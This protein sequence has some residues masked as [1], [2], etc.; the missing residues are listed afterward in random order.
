MTRVCRIHAVRRLLISAACL[1]MPCVAQA[2]DFSFLA[3]NAG[4]EAAVE[5]A[6]AAL[7]EHVVVAYKEENRAT[8]LDN[9]FRLQIV[10]GRYM[11]ALQTLTK[12]H[13]LTAD[14]RS[15]QTAADNVQDQIFTQAKLIEAAEGVA[16]NQAFQRAFREKFG[17]LDNR[18]SALV[19]RTL[20]ASKQ[21]LRSSFETAVAKQ[22]G[23]STINLPDALALVRAYQTDKELRTYAPLVQPL[24]AEDDQRRYIIEK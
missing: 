13:D 11:D 15:T 22:K 20:T 14:P 18:T 12:L 6:M 4:D 2:Q 5:N 3:G 19:V 7:A 17:T 8:F 10:S 23:R 16:F 9:L 1:L 21:F 24:I